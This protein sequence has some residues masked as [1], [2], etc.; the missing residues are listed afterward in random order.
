MTDMNKN[1]LLV[2]TTKERSQESYSSE[3]DVRVEIWGVFPSVTKARKELYRLVKGELRKE[4]GVWENTRFWCS[5]N[6][7]LRVVETFWGA[8]LH[9]GHYGHTE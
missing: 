4:E 2:K 9:I 6:V 8:P 3:C 7:E 5:R 1:V